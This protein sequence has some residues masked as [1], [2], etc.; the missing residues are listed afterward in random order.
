M[1]E[2]LVTVAKFSQQ[3]EAELAREALQE[4][5]LAVHLIAD[6]A[7]GSLPGLGDTV[8]GFVLQVPAADGQ[9]AMEI[10]NEVREEARHAAAED[11]ERTWLCPGCDAVVNVDFEMCPACGTLR[12]EP[13]EAAELATAVVRAEDVGVMEEPL[14]TTFV[15]DKVATRSLRAAVIGLLFCGLGFSIYGGILLL[16]I[17]ALGYS[18]WLLARLF[19]YHGELSG[20]G[21]RN[22]CLAILVDVLVF[23]L[24]AAVLLNPLL[25]IA[26]WR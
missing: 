11:A 18:V 15:G 1:T 12:E 13:E 2:D 6:V 3:L 4:E 19:V 22:L 7:G 16:A 9:R 8:G 5:G 17:P 14:P 24:L 21:L 23:V 20:S 26:R 25:L 10:L